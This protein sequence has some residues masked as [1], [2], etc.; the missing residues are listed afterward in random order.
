MPLRE[1]HREVSKDCYPNTDPTCALGP[2]IET[3][4][5]LYN[6]LEV[7]YEGIENDCFE[8]RDPDCVGYVWLLKRESKR[9]YKKGVPI[10]QVND[11]PSFIHSF[12]TKPDGTLD[13]GAPYPSCSQLCTDSRRCKIHADR[14][15]TC[16][17]YPIGLETLTD[18]TIVWALHHD[19]LHARRLGER[20]TL[21]EFEMKARSIVRRLSEKLRAEIVGTYHEV[22]SVSAFPTG[23]NNYSILE[24]CYV[25]M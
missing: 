8:C 21:Q 23:P 11:G 25:K 17:F 6:E 1:S 10:V 16:R 3:V 9:L 5:Q 2:A 24:M 18:G 22:H 7:L 14:P 15:L 4:P 13:I 20:G 19:C 12:L